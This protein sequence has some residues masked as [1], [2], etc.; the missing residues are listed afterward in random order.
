MGDS[1][2]RCSV[3]FTF[4][5]TL[6]GMDRSKNAPPGDR[7]LTECRENPCSSRISTETE[8]R[9][10]WALRRSLPA[11]PEA[12][13]AGGASQKA[14]APPTPVSYTHLRAHETPEHLVCR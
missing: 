4:D 3:T 10:R 13:I 11:P 5:P 7:S 9:T 6:F 12:V 8:T 2:G 14:K 1:P